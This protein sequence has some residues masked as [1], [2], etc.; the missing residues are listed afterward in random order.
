M[1]ALLEGLAGSRRRLFGLLVMLALVAVGAVVTGADA[2]S[3]QKPVV[4]FTVGEQTYRIRLEDREDIAGLH[5][6]AQN[7]SEAR[8]PVGRAVFGSSGVNRGYGWHIDPKSFQWAEVTMEVCDG[9]PR[10]VAPGAVP[11]DLFC[12]WAAE[13]TEVSYR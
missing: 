6:L 7:R 10:D 3:R 4:T 13:V 2:V 11:D 5:E 9:L 12:P 8:I 1:H